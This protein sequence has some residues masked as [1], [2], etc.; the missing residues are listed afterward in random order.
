MINLGQINQSESVFVSKIRYLEFDPL[1]PDLFLQPTNLDDDSYSDYLKKKLFRMGLHEDELY[2]FFPAR[3]NHLPDDFYAPVDT[4]NKILHKGKLVDV[5][6]LSP[7]ERI[8]LTHE[9]TY[10]QL[11]KYSNLECVLSTSHIS[12]PTRKLHYPEPF[13][14]SASFV[15]ND[16]GFIHVLHFQY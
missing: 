15:H 3:H 11:R 8:L 5:S 14:A 1:F 13:I 9:F 4:S 10:D 6:L 16:I 12:T 2:E 7:S